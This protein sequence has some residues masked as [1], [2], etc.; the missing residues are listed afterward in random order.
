MTTASSQR[1]PLY[2][3]RVHFIRRVEADGTVRVLSLRW[4]VPGAAIGQ[5][6]WVTLTLTLAHAHL[7]IFDAAPDAP[8]RRR[9]VRHAF[10]LQEP[11]RPHPEKA[12]PEAIKPSF[13]A[14]VR[15]TGQ[16]IAAQAFTMCWRFLGAFVPPP[17]SQSLGG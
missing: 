8:T 14:W 2:A 13:M 6:V 17:R 3:G 10:P 11:I 1:L 5:G 12:M 4:Q 15:E 16:A 9:L 7:D